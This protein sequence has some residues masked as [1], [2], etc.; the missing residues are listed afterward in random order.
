MF[1]VQKN[2]K[3][4][5]TRKSNMIKRIEIRLLYHCDTGAAGIPLYMTALPQPA[6]LICQYDEGKFQH[7]LGSQN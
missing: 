6:Y 1:S 7:F 5:K 2:L 4:Y 3:D